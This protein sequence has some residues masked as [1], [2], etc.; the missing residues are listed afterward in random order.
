[1]KI[2]SFAKINL[3][4]NVG[5]KLNSGLHDIQSNSVLINL[6]DKINIK[7]NKKKKDKII[8]KGPFG[9]AVKK[10]NNSVLNTLKILRISKKI[11]NHYENE[12]K[13]NI[14]VF[15]GLGGGTSNSYFVLKKILKNKKIDKKIFTLLEKKVGSDIK[16]FYFKQSYQKN[17]N[18]IVN[19]KKYFNLHLLLIYPYINCSTKKIYSKVKKVSKFSK[20]D[21]SNFDKI[22]KF[23]KVISNDNNDLQEIVEESYPQITRIL[24][25]IQLQK[26]CYFS[27]MTGSGSLCYGIFQN[28]RLTYLAAKKLNK[29]FPKYWLTITKTI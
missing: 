24:R 9:K 19:Y 27:R 16:L 5:K 22:D 13:K 2:K 4:L 11:V 3:S 1:M 25:N 12:V 21:Y 15:S 18:T 14:P 7:I 10:K 8:F 26:G 6:H 17:L 23:L 20:L 28:K 29:M